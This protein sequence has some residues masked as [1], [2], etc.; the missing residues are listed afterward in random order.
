MPDSKLLVVMDGSPASKRAVDYV[1]KLV[2]ARRGFRIW[3]ANVLPPLPP[4]LLEHGGSED[5]NEESQLDIQLKT[6]QQRFFLDAKKS[7]QKNLD[8]AQAALKKA[9]V[10]A[11]ALTVSFCEATDGRDAADCILRTARQYK[12]QTIVAGRQSASL[13]GELFGQELPEELLRH[14]KEFSIWFV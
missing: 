12:C 7:A 11:A 14:G 2:G 5:P 6:D 13:L 10:S 8:K 3:L 1:A 4:E 9:G